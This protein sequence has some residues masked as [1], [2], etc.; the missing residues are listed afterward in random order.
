MV[1]RFN[2][3]KVFVFRH[4]CDFALLIGGKKQDSIGGGAKSR[5]REV[6]FERLK[7]FK[8]YFHSH[9][10]TYWDNHTRLKGE[11]IFETILNV[12]L[13]LCTITKLDL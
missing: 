9:K 7:S 6:Q 4:V 13:I 1:S 10:V 11:N 2:G 3:R 8:N 5:R 12:Q